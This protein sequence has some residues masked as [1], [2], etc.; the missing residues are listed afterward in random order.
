MLISAAAAQWK[1]PTSECTVDKGIISHLPSKRRIS[2]GKVAAAASRLEPPKSVKL[3]DP[4]DWKI[5][6]QSKRRL[7]IPDKVLGKPIYAVDVVVPG[8]LHAAIVQ[9]PVFGG[10]L[11]SIDESAIKDARG[12]QQVIKLDG[13][14]AVLA[15]NWWRANEAAKKL[16]IEW[17]T[18]D[19]A[20]VSS[21]SIMAIFKAALDDPKAAEAKKTGDVD[22]AFATAAKIVEAEYSAPFLNH[23]TME[24]Q[25]CTAWVK[26]DGTVEVWAPTQNG[27]AA[28]ATAAE[29]AGVPL[30]KVEVHKTMLGGGFGRRGFQDYVRQAVQISKAAGNKP[31]KMLWSREEDMQHGFYRPASLTRLKAG[32][33]AQ[34]NVVAMSVR[35]ACPSIIAG[36]RPEAAR[37]GMDGTSVSGF[38]DFPYAVPNFKADYAMR[39]T[40]VPVGFWRGVGLSQNPFFR[41]CFIDELAHASGKD[42][43]EFRR[44]LLKDSPKNLAVLDA[45][46]KAAGWG[47][48]LRAGVHRGIAVQDGFG[49][50]TAAVVEASV[51]A[52]GEI[53]LHRCISAIDSGYVVNPDACRAQAEG[54]VVYGLT[55]AL[56]GENTVKDGRIAES[57]FHDY[58]MMKLS[59][60]PKVELVLVPSGGFWGGHGEPGLVSFAPALGNAIFAATG[61]RM[62]SMPF[63]HHD[64]K[65]A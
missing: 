27:E 2:Y 56:Y 6:G 36:I 20:R 5:A 62:R 9:S 24:P 14:V 34:G 40:H 52:S 39:N 31:V 29:T 3:K 49:S 12:I 1:V 8:M 58:P 44:A 46:A 11:K 57:N 65:K 4:K 10:T 53:K 63:K 59:E 64:L 43:Y 30:E 17:D 21:E 41:E 15:D 38:N 22:A 51:S 25:T 26:D 60:M 28:M 33:D 61:K 35:I 48:P 37:S 16:K 47:T 13:Y 32:L 42:P 55:A 50:F 18:G 54:A 23:A 19:N 7:D 45:V